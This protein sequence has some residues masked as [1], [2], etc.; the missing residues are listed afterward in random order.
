MTLAVSIPGRGE[1]RLEH[2]LLDVNGTVT[3]RGVLIDGVEQRLDRVRGLLEVRL[4]S[5]D[6]RGGERQRPA[7]RRCG[8]R[9][10]RRRVRP[11]ARSA[12]PHGDTALVD[13]WHR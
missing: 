11:A 3:N 13:A 10:G 12:R 9:F 4:V 5:A 8:L 7:R 1:L 2:V 6:T